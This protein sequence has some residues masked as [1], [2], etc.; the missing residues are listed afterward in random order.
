MQDRPGVTPIF[1]ADEAGVAMPHERINDNP[2][3]P[4]IAYEM[5]REYLSIEGNATQNLATFCQTYMEPTAVQ[6]MAETMEK[7][8]I[9]KDEYPLTADLENR[10]VSMLAH[11]W[12]AP[13]TS[14]P[15]SSHTHTTPAPSCHVSARP[16]GAT[17]GTSTVGSS[18]ACMLGGLALLFRWKNRARR[19]GINIYTS[20][21][22]NI[23]I[24]SGYQVCWEKFCRYWDVELR[25]VPLKRDKLSLDMG[26]VMNYVDSHTIGIIAILGITYTGAFDEVSRLDA[27]VEAYNADHPALPVGIHVDAASG[28][29]FAPF[30]EPELVWDFRLPNVWSI[31]SSGHKYGLVY[32]GIGWV[33]WRDA[34]AL[35]EELV[36]KVSYLGGEENTMAINFSRSASSIVGQYYV[37]LRNGT[38]G[39]R[40][41]HKRTLKVARFIAGELADMDAFEVLESATHLPVVCWTLSEETKRAWTLYDL[42]DRLR[43]SG[44]LVPAYPLPN[45][46]NTIT[47]LRIVV[48]ADLSMQLAIKLV[49]D[50]RKEV[51]ILTGAHL[52]AGSPS[53]YGG[54]AF[55]HSGRSRASL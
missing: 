16:H 50:I 24:S 7:N 23:V 44:W 53:P 25:E 12:H 14:P 20:Q 42:S 30:I 21:R 8:A 43:M 41:I 49:S 46:L 3:E 38:Q 39:F 6:L 54:S 28:G 2:I 34:N 31:N 33:L 22:P 45:D 4:V 47:V 18:E 10:C 17:P 36:F 29:L 9:D 5:V 27:L 11:L 52:V 55:D 26:N 32:P 35:P 48:R 13:Q 40:V 19:A 1:G 37:F 15:I 51:V